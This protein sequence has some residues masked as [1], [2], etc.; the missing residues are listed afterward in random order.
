MYRPRREAGATKPRYSSHVDSSLNSRQ[1]LSCVAYIDDVA[2]GGGGFTV[3][4][5]LCPRSRLRRK[6]SAKPAAPAGVARQPPQVQRLPHDHRRGLP[7]R[8]DDA[9]GLAPGRVCHFKSA[10]L[11]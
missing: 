3:D 5:P 4:G 10:H 11:H 9:A 2:P 1:R 6:G 8:T 7:D